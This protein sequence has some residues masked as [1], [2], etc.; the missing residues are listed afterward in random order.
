MPSF[1]S[2]LF[3]LIIGAMVCAAANAQSCQFNDARQRFSQLLQQR[4]LPG[5]ALLI[6]NRQG[7]LL[8]SYLGNFTNSTVVPIASATKLLSGVRMLQLAETG[9]LDLDAPV[10]SYLPQ[11][12]GTKGTMTVRQMFSH[13]SGYGDDSGAAIVFDSSLTL[14][15]A[16]DQIACCRPLNAGY[17]V[18][19]QF[20]YG[21]VSM[22]IA[23][24]VAEV[25]GGG[26]Y[27]AQWQ[28]ALG[29]PLGITTINWQGLG[30]TQNYGIAGSA[31]SS[32][33]D[34]GR[35][36]H[37]LANQGRSANNLRVLKPSTVAVLRQDRVGNL[38]VAYAPANA[39][40]V[41]KYSVG[42]WLDASRASPEDAFIHSLGAFGFFPWVDFERETF[43]VFMIRGTAGVNNTAVTVYNAML[44][45]IGA[46][47]DSNNCGAVE[48]FEGI[49][50]GDFER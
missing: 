36:L 8:E 20:S 45:S 48:V 10:S 25:I 3:T 30:A 46:E 44:S 39:G 12:T 40:T 23:G 34:Y 13:T 24:R 28:A 2:R 14:A 49:F 42:G 15:Q 31:Q 21:G 4:N 1:M 7:V 32:L 9:A 18:G 33:R 17:N 22:H 47:L 50:A 19:A 29:A 26:D 6:G 35:L 16:V 11:F 43:G 27:Q 41:V 5:G 37:M 38:P